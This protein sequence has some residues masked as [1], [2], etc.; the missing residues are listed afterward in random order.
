MGMKHAEPDVVP[1]ALENSEQPSLRHCEAVIS[2]GT[3]SAM[4]FNDADEWYEAMNVIM[5][6]RAPA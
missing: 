5:N 4:W 1:D 3:H 6:E 2:L